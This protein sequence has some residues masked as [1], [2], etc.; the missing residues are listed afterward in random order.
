VNDDKIQVHVHS[1]MVPI[2]DELLADARKEQEAFHRWLTA[3]PQERESQAE[4]ARQQRAQKR[5]AAGR[6]ELTLDALLDKLGFDRAYAEHLVQPYCDCWDTGDGWV[7]CQHAYD[8]G[9]AG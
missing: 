2:S 5:V 9:L 4:E 7:H 3:T 1:S 6:R 8:E